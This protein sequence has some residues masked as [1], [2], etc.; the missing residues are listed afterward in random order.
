MKNLIVPG[1]DIIHIVEKNNECFSIKWFELKNDPITK[2]V[3]KDHSINSYNNAIKAV[4]N[5]IR[6]KVKIILFH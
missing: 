4:Q 6:K 5:K 2:I 3:V 1:N